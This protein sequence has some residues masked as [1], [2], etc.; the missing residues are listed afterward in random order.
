MVIKLWGRLDYF[1]K[2]QFKTPFPMTNNYSVYSS[3]RC[4]TAK[5]MI[6]LSIVALSRPLH[7]FLPS[8]KPSFFNVALSMF[9]LTAVM[10]VLCGPSTF[11]TNG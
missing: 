8:M 4:Y 5:V 11:K 2:L 6:I 7:Y 10:S 3:Q 1:K 9:I